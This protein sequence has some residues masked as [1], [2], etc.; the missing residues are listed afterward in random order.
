MYINFTIF[1][2]VLCL[3]SSTATTHSK[4]ITDL[5]QAHVDI[6]SKQSLNVDHLERYKADARKFEEHR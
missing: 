6:A 3:K 5:Q 1:A 4:Q 2:N